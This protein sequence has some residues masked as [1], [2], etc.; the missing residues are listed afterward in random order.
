MNTLVRSSCIKECI[1]C[2]WTWQLSTLT[3]H[4]SFEIKERIV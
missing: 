4:F 2:V 1:Y 3:L